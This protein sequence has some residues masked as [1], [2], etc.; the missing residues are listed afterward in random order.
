MRTFYA[1]QR[2]IARIGSDEK[3]GNARLN[4]SLS[5][6]QIIGGE[7]IMDRLTDLANQVRVGDLNVA[8]F[9]GRAIACLATMS[10]SELLLL[11]L[12]LHDLDHLDDDLDA[13][14][15]ELRKGDN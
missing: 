1:V 4:E 10:T 2:R 8:E 15:V 13:D 14:V 11:V 6:K 5:A 9:R 7:V 3:A 12:H